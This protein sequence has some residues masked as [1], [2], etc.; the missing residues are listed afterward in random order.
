MN[1]SSSLISIHNLK[2]KLWNTPHTSNWSRRPSDKIKCLKFFESFLFLLSSHHFKY[3]YSFNHFLINL[4]VCRPSLFLFFATTVTFLNPSSRVQNNLCEIQTNHITCILYIQTANQES[5]WSCASI[6]PLSI[7][8]GLPQ[9]RKSRDWHIP[10][11]TP[12]VCK[13]GLSQ[14]APLAFLF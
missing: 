13:E 12:W 9:G 6:H 1:D 10:H 14:V 2:G 11:C 8:R 5:E 3:L 7:G 4:P